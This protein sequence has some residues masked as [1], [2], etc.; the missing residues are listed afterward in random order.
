MNVNSIRNNCEQLKEIL[1]KYKD[2]LAVT[3]T[4]LDETFLEFLMDGF[5]KPYQLDKNKNGE[6]IMLF[7]RDTIW[8]KIL[9]KQI[10][11]DDVESIFV[12]LHFRKRK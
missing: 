5:C 10:F 12:E 8:S 1:L 6:G 7:V 3:E 4:K 9:E 11:P 2:I